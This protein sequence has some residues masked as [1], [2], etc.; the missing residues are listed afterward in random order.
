MKV[1]DTGDAF[2]LPVRFGILDNQRRMRD[3][4]ESAV[5]PWRPEKLRAGPILTVNGRYFD[6]RDGARTAKAGFLVGRTGR[7]AF[8]TASPGTIPTACGWPAMP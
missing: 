8:S 1:T 2:L 5:V 3:Y 4:S 6:Y 7:T